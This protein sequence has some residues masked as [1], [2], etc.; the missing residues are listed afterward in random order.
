MS[1]IAA[2]L[3]LDGQP[4]TLAELQRMARALGSLGGDGEHFTV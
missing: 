3:N 2:I 1:A 4:V